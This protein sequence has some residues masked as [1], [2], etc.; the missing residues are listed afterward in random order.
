MSYA[1]QNKSFPWQS[2]WDPNCTKAPCPMPEPFDV[3][4]YKPSNKMTK[5][6]QQ[7]WNDCP[8]LKTMEKT[9]CTSP[10]FNYLEPE[11]RK[12]KDRF[13]EDPNEKCT[14]T[15]TC[16]ITRAVPTKC[17][18][19]VLPGCRTV[20]EPP[21]CRIFKSKS[22]CEKID[23]PEPSFTESQKLSPNK[24][25]NK[26]CG[27]LHVRSITEVYCK[28]WSQGLFECPRGKLC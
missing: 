23:C 10:K 22:D 1:Q 11:K 14:R 5:T 19:L 17:T 24:K 12:R 6:Y 4:H 9:L 20:R 15:D 27:C 7:T 2:M 26:E 28:I 3:T 25:V 16:N 18:K 8:I 21:R 13:C